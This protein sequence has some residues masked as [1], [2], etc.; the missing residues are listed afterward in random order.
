MEGKVEV[1]LPPLHERRP[2][3]RDAQDL[4]VE[5]Q[6]VSEQRRCPA[7]QVQVTQGEQGTGGFPRHHELVGH[8]LVDHGLVNH[9]LAITGPWH[10][11][12]T[13][14]PRQQNKASASTGRTERA[15]GVG[16]LRRT[17]TDTDTGLV[18]GIKLTCRRGGDQFRAIVCRVTYRLIVPCA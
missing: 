6:V 10:G 11:R 14:H 18:I 2:G 8:E 4:P 12:Q 5:R 17:D 3:H 7:S 15:I 16:R 9:A 1:Q 13:R